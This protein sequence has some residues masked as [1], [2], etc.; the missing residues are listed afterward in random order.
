MPMSTRTKLSRW[1]KVFGPLVVVL[2]AI[3]VAVFVGNSLSAPTAAE[4]ASEWV[5]K[6]EAEV[7]KTCDTTGECG[8]EFTARVVALTSELA[9][10][11]AHAGFDEIEELAIL[12][13]RAQ[14]QGGNDCSPGGYSSGATWSDGAEMSCEDVLTLNLYGTQMLLEQVKT[15]GSPLR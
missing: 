13:G 3:P 8:D 1:S 9:D 4:F 14:D 11:A 12:V 7:V 5:P 6:L 10:D 2:L 15:V